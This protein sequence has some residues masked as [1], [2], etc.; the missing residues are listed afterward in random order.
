MWNFL[1]IFA[2]FSIFQAASTL[3]TGPQIMP[4]GG[5]GFVTG[6]SI[7]CDQGVASC[8]NS[9]TVTKL[10]RVDVWGLYLFNRTA[11]CGNN[12]QTGCWQ[13]ILTFSSMPSAAVTSACN[14]GALGNGGGGPY[15]V[16]IAPSNTNHFYMIYNGSVFSSTNRGAPWN[17]CTKT[18]GPSFLT[19][20]NDASRT[21]G[22]FMAVDPA[23]ESNLLVGTP[24][25]GVFFSTN[26][27]ANFTL[28]TAITDSSAAGSGYGNALVAF[29]FSTIS[30]GAAQRA[31]ATSYGN[32]IWCTTTGLGGTW[33]ELN[34][35]NMPTTFYHMIIDAA[36]N[37]Y[38]CDNTTGGGGK[39]WKYTGSWAQVSSGVIAGNAESIAVDP[40]NTNHITVM[41]VSSP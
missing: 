32:G 16:A 39:L 21:M 3:V 19:N 17:A 30:G 13:N 12:N 37:L 4:I 28:V 40:N 11:I 5:G 34:S 22:N 1:V 10:A 15:E 38:V 31:C 9:G 7:E 27:C 20:S 23:N 41:N 26:G 24:A 14:G 6:L 25:N 29:D 2:A 8:N 18:G 35:A 33:N 36:G